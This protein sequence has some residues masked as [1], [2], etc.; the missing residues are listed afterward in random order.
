MNTIS[1]PICKHEKVIRRDNSWCCDWC[2]LE[3][4]PGRIVEHLA[5]AAFPE[6]ETMRDRFAMA[7]LIGV[8]ASPSIINRPV[9]ILAYDFAD[10]MMHARK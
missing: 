1:D 9:G 2:E 5:R 6:T 7:A 8:L 4:V 3:F 10:E